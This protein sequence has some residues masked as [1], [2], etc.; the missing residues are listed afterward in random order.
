[1][2]L[3]SSG[4]WIHQ[5]PGAEAVGGLC[6]LLQPGSAHWDVEGL[7]AP[8]EFAGGY[9]VTVLGRLTHPIDSRPSAFE[10]ALALALA[11][12]PAPQPGVE[13]PL[14]GSQELDWMWQPA[15]EAFTPE[16]PVWSRVRRVQPNWK[17]NANGRLGPV[18]GSFETTLIWNGDGHQPAVEGDRSGPDFALAWAQAARVFRPRPGGR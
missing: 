3:V 15:V 4:L 8:A 9:A 5:G 6:L 13:V 2:L 18:G 11:D 12:L 14:T 16:V 1:M 7:S 10:K 17:V